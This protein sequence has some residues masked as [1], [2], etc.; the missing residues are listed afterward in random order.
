MY[1]WSVLSAPIAEEFPGW[2]KAEMSA[3]MTVTLAMFCIGGITGGIMQRKMRPKVLAWIAAA[4]IG[5][6]FVI[7]SFSTS[8]FPLFTGF[9]IMV[10]LGAGFAYNAAMNSIAKKFPDRH[11]LASGILLFGFGMGSFVLGKI[12]AEM[13]PVLPDGWRT[14][15]MII[16]AASFAVPAIC[17]FFIP[18]IETPAVT[19]QNGSAEGVPTLKMLIRADFW[20]LFV[21]K[22]M[23]VG[24]GICVI[25]Q[26][27]PILKSVG[28]LSDEGT[29]ALMVGIISVFNGTGRI[30]FGGM[31]DRFGRMR[32]TY[33]MPVC[34]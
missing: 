24:S 3:I 1:G 28:G 5:A 6:G 20:I 27:A 2:T 16:G 11:G 14:A 4:L 19:E 8:T 22:I 9:G 26:A 29:I 15:F 12:Y 30:I 31:Y 33:L 34:S 32:L 10:G 25:S 7:S 17:A 13:T 23:I 21:W 18:D